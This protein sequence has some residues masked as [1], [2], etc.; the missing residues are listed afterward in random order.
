M[1]TSHRPLPAL[2]LLAI[3][4]TLVAAPRELFC[5]PV[6]GDEAAVS[7]VVVDHAGAPVAGAEVWLL[8]GSYDDEAPQRRAETVTDDTGRFRFEQ[9]TSDEL[10]TP[11]QNQRLAAFLARDRQHRFGWVARLNRANA[12]T[13][14]I[15]LRDAADFHGKLLGADGQP[16]AG[17]AVRPRFFYATTF[18]EQGSEP[19]SLPAKLCDEF[20]ATTAQD[21]SFVLRQ[22]PKIGSVAAYVSAPGHGRPNLNWDLASSITLRLGRAGSIAGAVILPAEVALP[23]KLTLELRRQDEPATSD[24]TFRLYYFASAEVAPDGGFEFADVPPGK[25]IVSLR[26]DRQATLYGFPSPPIAVAAGARVDDVKLR[27]QRAIKVTGLAVDNQYNEPVKDVGL[28]IST[29]GPDGKWLYGVYETTDAHGRFT[30]YVRPGKVVIKP[31]ETPSGYLAALD[32]LDAEP[33][34]A[35]E[36]VEA[37]IEI[38]RSIQISGVVVDGAGQPVP[39]AELHRPASLRGLRRFDS[40]QPTRTDASG[41]FV[42]DGIDPADNLSL[43]VRSATAASDGAVLLGPE[44]LLEPLRLQI[45]EA[46]ACRLHGRVVDESGKPAA[47]VKLAVQSNRAYDSKRINIRGLSTTVRVEELETDDDGRFESSALWP[48]DAYHVAITVEGYARAQSPRISGKAGELHDLGA[49]LLR[50][51]DGLVAGRVLDSSGKPVEG[52]EVFNA[53]DGLQPVSM[54]T[55]ATGRF[56]LAGLFHGPVYVFVRKPGHRF[57]GASAAAGDEQVELTLWR[58]DQPPNVEPKAALPLDAADH[59]Q[60]AR[61]TIEEL[62]ALPRAKNKWLLVRYMARIDPRQATDWATAAGNPRDQQIATGMSERCEDLARDPNGQFDLDDALTAA[63]GLDDRSAVHQWISIAE[64]I[65]PRRPEAALPLCEE[66]ALRLRNVQPPARVWSTGELGD[67]F[68][69]LD[70]PDVGHKLLDEAERTALQLTA[71]GHEAFARGMVAKALARYDLARARQLIEPISRPEGRDRYLGWLAEVLADHDL[72]AARAIVA[73]MNS[74]QRA[75]TLRNR[76]LMQMAY[77][78]AAKRPQEAV[79]LIDAMD[80]DQQADKFRAEAWGWLAV[81]L[82]PRD[83][84]S[85]Q[86]LIDRSLALHLTKPE[87]FRSWSNYGG[88]PVFAAWTARQA[89]TAGYPD[90]HSV[91][92]RV[93][94]TREENDPVRRLEA[95]V[96]VALVL[97]F[98]DPATSR[99]LLRSVEPFSDL[100]GSGH[101]NTRRAEWLLAWALCDI[102]HAR[103]LF[104]RELAAIAN[105]EIDLQHSDLLRAADMLSHPPSAWQRGFLQMNHGAVWMPGEE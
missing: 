27:L 61:W 32:H 76:T 92:M 18:R 46:N 6:N 8:G 35:M 42:L 41:A 16:I 71:V 84:K 33:I 53:G 45:S 64:A 24:E 43:R 75:G 94:A 79:G 83:P 25:Y 7:G 95:T 31:F 90:M 80:E 98:S 21:G 70:R 23:E 2:R 5:A 19:L 69:R 81:V 30:A 101:S 60:L 15:E 9:F 54:V 99:Q 58:D 103:Q 4:L 47:G 82:A 87:S 73:E 34:D 105:D 72:G 28:Q 104:E 48:R 68:V 20:T 22:L 86:T 67:L 91:V 39:G 65:L 51:T 97:S 93:L 50:R 100:I 57:T 78:V 29:L 49:I 74:G 66:A 96:A 38:E 40:P 102:E 62:W 55:D 37:I 59:E 36:D 3:G 11:Q 13:L 89:L 10:L 44:K 17:A 14:K 1:R 26:Q 85:A 12:A 77:R 88:S 52:A 63:S 56:R